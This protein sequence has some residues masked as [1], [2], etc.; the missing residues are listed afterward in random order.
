MAIV[1]GMVMA[2]TE[3]TQSNDIEGRAI[4][5]NSRQR[6]FAAAVEIS[7]NLIPSEA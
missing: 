4:G 6:A 5:N 2:G 7:R 3:T 1:M